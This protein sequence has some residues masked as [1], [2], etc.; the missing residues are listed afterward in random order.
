METRN[1]LIGVHTRLNGYSDEGYTQHTL[2]QVREMGASWIVELFPWAYVQPRSRY[3]YDWA[4]ADM[5]V[6][7]AS[8]QGLKII[9]RIDIVPEWARPARLHRPRA[10][11][12]AL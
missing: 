12:R 5:I 4:G 1:P 2:E 7:H 8:R 11:P 9:A 10:R 3:G 6:E